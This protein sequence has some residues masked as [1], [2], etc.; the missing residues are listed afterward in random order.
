MGSI[1]TCLLQVGTVYGVNKDLSV[2]SRRI[3]WGQ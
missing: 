3:I 2:T 1:R